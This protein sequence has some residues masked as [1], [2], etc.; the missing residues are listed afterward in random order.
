MSL[1]S[2]V[3]S[4][5]DDAP[6]GNNLN[7]IN[8]IK[9]LLNKEDSRRI[10]AEN[11]EQFHLNKDF[12]L[13]K[14]NDDDFALVS[15]YNKKGVKFY[16]PVL[17]ITYDYDFDAL[18]VIDVEAGQTPASAEV[19]SYNKELAAYC[20][21]HYPTFYKSLV[22]ADESVPAVFYFVI[23]DENMNDANF[24][25]GRWQSFYKYDSGT[26]Q[27]TGEIRVK[28]HYYED[29]NV[30]LN[31]G[32]KIS[33]QVGSSVV[34]AIAKA[35]TVFET[36]VFSKFA[37]LNED[38]FKNLRRQLPINRSKVRWGDAIGNYKLG[39]DVVGGRH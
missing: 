13:V 35:E 6:P 15:K 9:I 32:T 31:S 2:I 37:N 1:Q 39:Q 10:I 23:V 4:M 33:E 11:L 7:L 19:E 36:A 26:K 14:I 21:K 5:I 22:V 16:D 28:I 20:A 38:L 17:N 27:L 8:D 12:K 30:I 34:D 3:A 29:G 18:K 25:N 24:Y